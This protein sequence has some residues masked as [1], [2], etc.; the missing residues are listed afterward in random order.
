MEKGK[1]LRYL[2]KSPQKLFSEII[3]MPKILSKN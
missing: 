1:I 3:R 2:L